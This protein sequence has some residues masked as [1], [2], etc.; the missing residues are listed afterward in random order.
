MYMYNAELSCM[1]FLYESIM[2]THELYSRYL[3]PVGCWKNEIT[4][5][6]RAKPNIFDLGPRSYSC[7]QF[8]RQY[9]W[10]YLH[11]HR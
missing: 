2:T 1:H 5:K 9:L 8:T 10:F 6:L 11:V 7:L 3:P 4:S